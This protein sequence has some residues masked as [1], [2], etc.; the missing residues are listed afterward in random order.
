MI[1]LAVGALG[2]RLEESDPHTDSLERADT[3]AI[4]PGDP[5][6]DYPRLMQ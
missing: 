5:D 4:S 2:V 3:E 1:Q 6:A